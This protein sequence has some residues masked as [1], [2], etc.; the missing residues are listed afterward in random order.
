MAD[1]DRADSAGLLA[2]SGAGPDLPDDDR[3]ARLDAYL[4]DVKELQIRDGLHVFG[5]DLDPGRR[6]HLLAALRLASPGA[7][8]AGLDASA[9]GEREGLLAALAGRFVPPGPA[10]APTRGRADVL[11]TGR[12]LFT[13]DPRGIPTATAIRLAG[14]AA[15][16]LLRRHLQDHGEYPRTL[17]ID[18]WG[19]ATMRTGGEDLA[20]ALLLMGVRPSWD[21]GS[22]R[23]TGFEVLPIAQL[24]HPRIDVTLRI[25]GLFR[26]AFAAQVELFDAAVRAVAERDEAADWNPLA[27]ACRGLD[28]VAL[29]RAN[30][31]IYGPAPGEFGAGLGERLDRGAWEDASELGAAYLAASAAAYGKALDGAADEAGFARRVAA[32]H[33]FL[34]QQDHRE[35]DLLDS[36]SWAAHEG[37]FAAAAASLG[38][39]PALYHADTAT[40][41]APRVRTVAEEVARVVRGRAANPVWIAGMMRHGY[42]GAAE[43]ARAVDALHG[44]AATLPDRLDRQFDLVFDATL[45]DPEVDRFLRDANPDARA[46]L[47]ARFREARRRGLWQSRRNTVAAL[48]GDAP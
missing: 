29:R 26:D 46:A 13:L 43:I 2:E 30:A 10:G 17:V 20:L 48:L 7:D 39:A 14:P 36:T 1:G 44:F 37:G 8:P 40:P 31:R 18:L 38:A 4:C 15:A 3:L 28:G 22:G 27:A 42:R 9:A 5:R 41:G 45:G 6:D 47:A 21:A 25:S 35:T 33:A 24:E 19:S 16:E 12:N 32:A 23:V 34:H 11:P